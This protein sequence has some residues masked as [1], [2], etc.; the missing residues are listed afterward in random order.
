MQNM[1]SEAPY[2]TAGWE[3]MMMDRDANRALLSAYR[4]SITRYQKLLKT[5]L[6]EV[7]Q[8]Y[9]KERLLSC[10]AA[11]KALSGPEFFARRAAQTF[12]HPAGTLTP[13]CSSPDGSDSSP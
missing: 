13:P 4:N 9:I 3:A 1:A 7:E 11:V 6:S 5:H 10:T 12:S 2:V 8:N